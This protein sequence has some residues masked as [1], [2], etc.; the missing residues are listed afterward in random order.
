VRRYKAYLSGESDKKD[1]EI[2]VSEQRRK[3]LPMINMFT[4]LIVNTKQS[5]NVEREPRRCMPQLNL[6]LHADHVAVLR[7]CTGVDWR[8]RHLVSEHK[9]PKIYS[10]YFTGS[11]SLDYSAVRYS[12]LHYLLLVLEIYKNKLARARD[13]SY[14]TNQVSSES[15]LR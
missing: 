5:E 4:V 6:G 7:L 1:T 3:L 8:H 11:Y 2:D 15:M 12:P 13:H 10:Y 9:Y 14:Q